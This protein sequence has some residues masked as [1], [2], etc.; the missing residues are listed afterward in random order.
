MRVDINSDG[1]TFYNESDIIWRGL[2]KNEAESVM[3][4]PGYELHI[5]DNDGQS[6]EKWVVQGKPYLP[7]GMMECQNL[8]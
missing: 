3:I 6:G 2:N 7:N 1:M 8:E 5:F 4:P